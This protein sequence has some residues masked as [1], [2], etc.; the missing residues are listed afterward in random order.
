MNGTPRGAGALRRLGLSPALQQGRCGGGVGC[1]SGGCGASAPGGDH[2]AL[3]AR[4]PRAA[5]RLSPSLQGWA[6]CPSASSRRREWR[7]G[8]SPSQKGSGV[9]SGCGLREAAEAQWPGG[10]VPARRPS[11]AECPPGVRAPPGPAPATPTQVRGPGPRWPGRR[12][13]ITP[14]G[15]VPGRP[16]SPPAHPPSRRLAWVTLR[17]EFIVR[18]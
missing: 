15:S 6:T 7:K 1:P 17:K 2:A 14:A 16:T 8:R 13:A 5:H 12:R 9:I 10:G 3:P 18:N 11:P 4:R